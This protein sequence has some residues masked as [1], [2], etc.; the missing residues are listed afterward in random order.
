MFQILFVGTHIAVAVFSLFSRF[1]AIICRSQVEE[2]AR[3]FMDK[4]GR[5]SWVSFGGKLQQP[6][7]LTCCLWSRI[8]KGHPSPIML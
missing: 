1:S 2:F 5:D 6:L 3:R 7:R 4:V 8:P